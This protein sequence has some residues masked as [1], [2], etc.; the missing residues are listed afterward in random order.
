M[1]LPKELTGRLYSERGAVVHSE[2]NSVIKTDHGKYLLVIKRTE[3]LVVCCSINSERFR[4]KPEES[5]P[6]IL[7]RENDFLH[8]DSYVDCAQIFAIDESVFR[9]NMDKGVFVPIGFLSEISMAFVLRAGQ[10][11]PMLSKVEQDYFK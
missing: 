6:R 8:H 7:K 3:S 1:D 11:C 4:F 5:Q 10:T 2:V 9:G